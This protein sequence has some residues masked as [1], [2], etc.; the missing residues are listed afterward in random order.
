M[1]IEE[2]IFAKLEPHSKRI[3]RLLK[4]L[5]RERK[6]QLGAFYFSDFLFAS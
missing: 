2:K 3:S 5:L 1:T 4:Y 6:I